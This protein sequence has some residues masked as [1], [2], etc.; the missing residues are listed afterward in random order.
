MKHALFLALYVVPLS[1]F[2]ADPAAP[3]VVPTGGT[4]S[5][6]TVSGMIENALAAGGVA[7]TVVDYIMVIV[8]LLIAIKGLPFGDDD[9][10]TEWGKLVGGALLLSMAWYWEAI[11]NAIFTINIASGLGS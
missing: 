11:P 7:N 9:A 10:K 6:S 2:A 1:I 3:A 8:G 5:S 4:L